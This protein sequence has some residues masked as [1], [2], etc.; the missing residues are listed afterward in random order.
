LQSLY[1]LSLRA[2][3]HGDDFTILGFDTNL[4][5]FKSAITTK[6]QVKIEGRIGPNTNVTKIMHVLN[7]LVEWKEDGIHYKADQRHAQIIVKTLEL[8]GSRKGSVVP[9]TKEEVDL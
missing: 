7:R 3:I 5:W 6:W 1:F 9:G 2:V 8:E 4:D